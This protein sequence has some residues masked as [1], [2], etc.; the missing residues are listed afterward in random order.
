MV[1]IKKI[2]AEKTRAVSE[3]LG[4]VKTEITK[5]FLGQEKVIDSLLRAILCNGN[6]LLEGVPGIAKT[7]AIK[8]LAQVSGCSSKRVQ[9][10]V[11][12]LPSDIVGVTTYD[13]KKG[14]SVVK[15]PIFANFVIADEINRS[16]P[17]TQSALMEA[18]QERQVTIGKE[19]FVLPKPFFVMAS[20]NPIENAGVYSLPEAQLDRFLFKINFSYPDEKSEEE[21][22]ESNATFKRFEDFNLKEV[23]SPEKIIDLQKMVHQIY[24]DEKIRK[25]ILAIVNKSR[26]KDF[27]HGDYIELGC[28]P[29]ATIALYIAAKSQALLNGRNY[30][31]P[32]DVKDVAH[33]CLRHRLILS[34]RAR[35]DKI[36]SD[37]I[38]DEI[39]KIV[40]VP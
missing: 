33:E 13:P 34:Y 22:M 35:A 1:E 12:L 40:S 5:V 38:I 30:V 16:P 21:I 25:Y 36:D 17:K 14:F 11:D 7:L 6:I 4:K 32:Q 19:T 9:F 39:L 23:L 8:A 3:S 20:Q 24:L 18:M 37:K 27:G 2:P 10:T 15:G 26:K 31:V 29:R 28:S